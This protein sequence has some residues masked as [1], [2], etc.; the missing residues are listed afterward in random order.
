MEETDI[1]VLVTENFCCPP[2]PLESLGVARRAG[3]AE[4]TSCSFDRLALNLVAAKEFDLSMEIVH[5]VVPSSRR[6][7]SP[8]LVE[9][10]RLIVPERISGYHSRDF[11]ARVSSERECSR[12]S[13][14]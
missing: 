12:V 8:L 7:I 13:E 11:C 14:R 5:S 2:N 10:N 1:D 9:I 4:H 3:I 6:T